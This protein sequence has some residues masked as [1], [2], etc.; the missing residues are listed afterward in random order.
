[1]LEREI[2]QGMV[3]GMVVLEEARMLPPKHTNK[4]FRE[5]SGQKK[6]D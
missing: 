5:C 1:M 3:A 2:Q 6:A 4:D